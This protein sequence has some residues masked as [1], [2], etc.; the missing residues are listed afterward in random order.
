[1]EIK[2]P[3]LKKEFVKPT[4]SSELSNNKKSRLGF[5]FEEAINESNEYYLVKGTAVIHKKP[6]P[7]QIVNVNYPKRSAAKITEAYFKVPS[8]TD[9]NGIYKGMYIDFEAK[10]TN[11]D[12]FPF[13]HIYEHQILHLEQVASQGGIAFLLIHFNKRD[14]IYLLDITL[15][16][17]CYKASKHEGRKSINYAYFKEHGVFIKKGF[18]PRVR[19]LEAIDEY[20]N[21]RK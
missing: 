11:S 7:I 2:Y 15:L 9:Y 17:Q 4:Q 18:A 19:Y 1:M 10:Q 6:T 21:I 13:A 16:S 8:T 14:E 3:N 20:Y 5:S 12:L